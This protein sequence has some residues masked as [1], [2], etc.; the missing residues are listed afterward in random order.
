MKMKTVQLDLPEDVLRIIQNTADEFL[1]TPDLVINIIL[2]IEIEKRKLN[3]K[4]RKG[5]K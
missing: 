1:I 2:K 4:K 3:K 5:S